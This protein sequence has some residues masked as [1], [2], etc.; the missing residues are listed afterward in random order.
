MAALPIVWQ[1]KLQDAVTTSSGESESVAWGQAVKQ[2][3]KIAAMLE[4]TS[5]GKPDVQGYTDNEA[6]RIAHHHGFSARMGH[7]RKHAKVNFD[8]MRATLA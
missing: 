2:G 7:L 6:L 4:Q 5:V 1:A 3:I 8:L